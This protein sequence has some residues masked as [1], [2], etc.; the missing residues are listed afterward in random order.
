MKIYYT[1]LG[2]N[3]DCNKMAADGCSITK[4]PNRNKVVH[5]SGRW[6]SFSKSVEYLEC[7]NIQRSVRQLTDNLTIFHDMVELSTTPHEI[8]PL[9]SSTSHNIILQDAHTLDIPN[10]C[11]SANDVLMFIVDI[12]TTK[13]IPTSHHCPG[14][15]IDNWKHGSIAGFMCLN[16]LG[17]GMNTMIGVDVIT[18][19]VVKVQDGLEVSQ[20]ITE[21]NVYYWV[22]ILGFPPEKSKIVRNAG[23]IAKDFQKRKHPWPILPKLT[24]SVPSTIV[25]CDTN[26][27][28]VES[29]IE[30]SLSRYPH[31]KVYGRNIARYNANLGGLCMRCIRS[32]GKTEV[33]YPGDIHIIRLENLENY[34]FPE[35]ADR[36]VSLYEEEIS[37]R[38]REAIHFI[39]LVGEGIRLPIRFRK[40][41]KI[42]YVNRLCE[43]GKIQPLMVNKY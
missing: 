6:L 29:L 12:D 17:N 26:F 43:G 10:G 30:E 33:W 27:D 1:Y 20:P 21:P 32:T 22:T 41:F 11:L 25:L 31:L 40:E 14:E 24:G 15:V 42:R 2:S 39:T 34:N 23:E 8:Y 19:N 4:V 28:K 5:M 37:W 36:L 35:Y 3:E 7:L 38:F 18:Q 9:A 13:F 16:K